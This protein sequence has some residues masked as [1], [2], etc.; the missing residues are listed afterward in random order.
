MC[1]TVCWLI[2]NR[3]VRGNI[4]STDQQRHKAATFRNQ[5]RLKNI[6]NSY[7][8]LHQQLSYFT[9]T[10]ILFYINSYFILHQ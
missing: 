5:L 9:S 2:D 10:V 3:E 8:I 4:A 7:L 1:R 6:T